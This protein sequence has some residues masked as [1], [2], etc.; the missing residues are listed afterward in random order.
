MVYHILLAHPL[1]YIHV[2]Y[3]STL[4]IIG[5]VAVDMPIRICLDTQ[6]QLFEVYILHFCTTKR[7]NVVMSFE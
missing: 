6:F 1:V 7:S 4:A 3:F 5:S 2:S